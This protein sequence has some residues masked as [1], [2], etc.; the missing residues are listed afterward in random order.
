MRRFR[1]I[2]MEES[3]KNYLW[4]LHCERAIGDPKRVLFEGSFYSHC[5]FCDAP[6]FD[7]WDFAEFRSNNTGYPAIPE[8]GVVYPL[9]G[10][11]S[12]RTDGGVAPLGPPRRCGVVPPPS[13]ES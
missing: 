9:Y 1:G 11:S 3:I 10:S 2:F 5:P 13:P 12:I 8:H 7:L 4:C 6:E